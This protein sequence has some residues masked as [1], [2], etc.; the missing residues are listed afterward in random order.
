MAFCLILWV[1]WISMLSKYICVS[2]GNGFQYRPGYATT[3]LL[4]D[5]HEDVRNSLT[6][7]EANK[8][9]SK[10]PTSILYFSFDD[11][12]A[13][14]GKPPEMQNIP[15]VEKIVNGISR[16]W[17]SNLFEPITFPLKPGNQVVD[18]TLN[19]PAQGSPLDAF[20]G[21][22][23]APISLSG[24][25]SSDPLTNLKPSHT[26]TSW[27]MASP[28]F[29]SKKPA[30]SGSEE[31]HPS[32]FLYRHVFE[33]SSQKG[34]GSSKTPS[35]FEGVSNRDAEHSGSSSGSGKPQLLPSMFKPSPNHAS[36]ETGSHFGQG[37]DLMGLEKVN[38]VLQKKLPMKNPLDS[39]NSQKYGQRNSIDADPSTAHSSPMWKPS[40][41]SK[42]WMMFPFFFNMVDNWNFDFPQMDVKPQKSLS[43][44]K[45]SKVY[46][47]VYSMMPQKRIINSKSAY[48]RGRFVLSKMT[49]TPE[50][51]MQQIKDAP[52]SSSS[53]RPTQPPQGVKI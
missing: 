53:K 18:L 19:R 50:H 48:K 2:A 7:D 42:E 30:N 14:T 31:T 37:D 10:S 41:D 25:G 44:S 46:Q 12:S 1:S 28:G 40:F 38:S 20:S 9:T 45:N 15:F 39:N 16:K 36:F 5:Q 24:T 32:P 34:I 35:L 8:D 52:V 6:F 4:D 51:Q 29:L 43:S 17:D 11:P 47:P 23:P 26:S 13:Q 21:I 33:G 22:K 49:Y 3:N 27:S